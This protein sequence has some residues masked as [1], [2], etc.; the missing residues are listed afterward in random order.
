MDKVHECYANP[1]Q[2]IKKILTF[3]SLELFASTVQI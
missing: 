2:I 1:F 3:L